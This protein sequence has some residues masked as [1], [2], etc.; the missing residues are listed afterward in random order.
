ML[1]D[2]EKEVVRRTRNTENHHLPK[3]ANSTDYMYA[4]AF[5]GLIGYLY[6]T[7]K[8]DRLKEILDFVA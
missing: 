6:L 4:T 2:K 1:T 7:K 3:N 8:F 5:E